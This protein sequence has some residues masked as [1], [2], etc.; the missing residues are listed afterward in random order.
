MATLIDQNPE[1]LITEYAINRER[2]LTSLII[3]S[4]SKIVDPSL[5]TPA[6]DGAISKKMQD[7]VDE[8]ADLTKDALSFLRFVNY[9]SGR[10]KE[11]LKN[12]KM[13]VSC[14]SN[15]VKEI[16]TAGFSLDKFGNNLDLPSSLVIKEFVNQIYDSEN[17]CLK[18]DETG[19]TSKELS[20]AF[21][22]FLNI[23]GRI[24]YNEKRHTENVR[25]L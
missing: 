20:T 2:I 22:Q 13:N 15:I 4:I 7:N 24:Q 8:E 23:E 12:K 19:K 11:A 17:N 10:I 25:N 21:S 14:L 9:N 3:Y 6:L 18:S 5:K 1:R 16:G